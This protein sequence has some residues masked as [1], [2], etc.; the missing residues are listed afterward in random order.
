M[1]SSTDH[2][3][4]GRGVKSHIHHDKLLQTFP[5]VSN[6]KNRKSISPVYPGN[7]IA[8]ILTGLPVYP[9]DLLSRRFRG[10]EC[11]KAY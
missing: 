11:Y 8:W 3:F 5:I 9:A 4:L 1:A 2:G 6:L 10:E 7:E